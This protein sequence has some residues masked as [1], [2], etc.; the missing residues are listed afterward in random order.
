MEKELIEYC[1]GFC[2]HKFSRLVGT[3]SGEKHNK[4][5]DQVKCKKCNNFLKTWK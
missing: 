4:V 2:G 3:S 1:C 5:S